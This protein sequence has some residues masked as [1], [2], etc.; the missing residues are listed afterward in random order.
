MKISGTISNYS[1]SSSSSS[2]SS[3]TVLAIYLTAIFFFCFRYTCGHCRVLPSIDVGDCVCCS[4]IKEV[5]SE[6]ERLGVECITQ[7]ASFNAAVLDPITLYVAWQYFTERWR[8]QAWSFG[9]RNND[10][11]FWHAS[12]TCKGDSE[13]LAGNVAGVLH[14][15]VNE[16]EWL[17]TLDG[18]SGQCDHGPLEDATTPWLAPGSPPHQKLREIIM[19]KRF[20]KSMTYYRDFRHTGSLESFH[21]T[22]L[23]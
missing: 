16:H 10:N 1:S 20:L 11:H 8:R 6:A 5:A 22:L 7:A 23:M 17:F 12:Q 2:S 19:D 15:V 14:H 21:S 9:G 18:R 4:E 3:W 13:K